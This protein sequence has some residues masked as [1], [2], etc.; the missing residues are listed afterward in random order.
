MTIDDLNRSSAAGFGRALGA[1]YEHSPWIAE[2]AAA[3]RPFA[4]VAA[5]HAAMAGVVAGASAAEQRALVAAHPDLAGRLARAGGLAEASAGEQAG[6]G[7]D[8]LS[9][10]EFEQFDALNRAYRARFG[11]PFVIAVRRHTRASVLAA[12]HTRLGH[13]AAVELRTA[14]AEIDAIARFRLD[15]LLAE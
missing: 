12:F 10:A 15:A 7:L 4:D 9:D 14:L 8:R 11:F 1:V 3:E 5:L 6:L 2:R 13:D